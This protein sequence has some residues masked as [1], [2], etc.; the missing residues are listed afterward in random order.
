MWPDVNHFQIITQETTSSWMHTPTTGP[1]PA[2]SE[3]SASCRSNDK[4]MNNP[5]FLPTN[6]KTHFVLPDS[7]MPETWQPPHPGFVA[8]FPL[9]TAHASISL[10]PSKSSKRRKSMSFPCLTQYHWGRTAGCH[11]Q[12]DNIEG[13]V[14]DFPVRDQKSSWTDLWNQPTSGLI[15][16]KTH[17]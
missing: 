8:L 11:I 6:W 5:E 13:Q 16:L 12:N 7:R 1:G 3:S 15:H 17:R 9:F 10:R 4:N 14:G 2:S